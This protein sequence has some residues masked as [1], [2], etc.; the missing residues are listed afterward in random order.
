M[1]QDIAFEL[2]GQPVEVFGV[3]ASESLLEILRER[4]GVTS[5]KPGCLSGDCGCCNVHL[6]GDVVPSCLVLAPTVAGRS[7]R[8]VE[9]LGSDG[10]LTPVQRA[11]HEHYAAQCG[12]CTSGQIMSAE[13]FLERNPHPTPEEAKRAM[14][15]NLCRCTGY[16]KILDAVLA[17]A[18]AERARSAP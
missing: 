10:E 2:N 16:R 13:A 9:G 14:T 7:V 15:G 4:L 11:F 6:D 1:R 18:G 3:S 12:F 17:A 8:T 5:P